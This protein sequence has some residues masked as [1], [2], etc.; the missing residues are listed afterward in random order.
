MS[1]IGPAAD[2]M[3]SL[4]D[5]EAVL[6]VVFEAPCLMRSA[7]TS[8]LDRAGIPWR[9]AF[10]SASLSGIWAA[11]GAG[12]GITVRTHAGMPKHLCVLSG[13]PQL[14]SVGLNLHRAEAGPTHVIQR[15]SE[16]MHTSLD[17]SR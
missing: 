8:A 10:T 16:I 1:W 3:P 17:E 4:E 14:P 5:G 15:L 12:L 9:I 2:K 11:V 13:L 6:L 7:A